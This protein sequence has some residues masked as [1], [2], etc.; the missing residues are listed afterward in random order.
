TETGLA[1]EGCFRA[2]QD[3]YPSGLPNNVTL[4][5]PRDARTGYIQN[6]QLSVQR[7]LTSNMLVDVAYVGNHA[8]KLVMLV[9]LN[10]ARPNNPGENLLV[11]ARRPISGFRSIS[12]VLPA[13]F[14]NYH[15]LQ[16]K[17]ERRFSKGL[18]VLNSFTSSKA[19][20]NVSQVLEEPNGNT[21]TP[22]NFYNIAADRGLS[23]YDEPLNNTTSV[24]WDLPF[25]RG[26]S[27]AGALPGAL[28]A[29][30]GGWTVTVINTMRSGQTI[31]LPYA[32][33]PPAS[34]TAKP[35]TLLGGVALRSNSSG[36]VRATRKPRTHD[37]Y[38]SIPNISIPSVNQPFGNA[39]RN[40]ARS[41]AF[42]QLDFG[43][44]KNFPLP[45]TEATRVEFRAEFFNLFNKTNFG[46]ANSD[47]S[48]GGFG[49]IRSTFPARQIQFALKLSF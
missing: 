33:T 42:Y 48:S 27:Y 13:A 5:M 8:T 18:Y 14:S 47:R 11:N 23:A 40:I 16:V 25:G 37:N 26:R 46:A 2:T 41:D 22:Q 1:L 4:Y 15:A 31:N 10:Q 19:I 28:E 12:A 32:P 39:G 36:P 44:Q 3:G 45:I 43:L 38:F 29:A 20:D 21:G 49:Q 6:W 17:F 35:P 9:D 24:V 7:E 34:G 30:V